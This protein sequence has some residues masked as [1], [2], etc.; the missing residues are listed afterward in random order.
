M[1]SCS[2]VHIQGHFLHS[3]DP[4][5]QRWCDPEWAVPPTPAAISNQENGPTSQ[6]DGSNPSGEVLSAQEQQADSQC[7]SLQWQTAP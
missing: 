4:L 5:A 6:S 1:E 3:P 7:Q 2:Q